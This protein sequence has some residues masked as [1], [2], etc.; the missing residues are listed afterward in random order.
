[1][2]GLDGYATV[3]AAARY[4]LTDDIAL[5]LTVTNLLDRREIVSIS[6]FT[7][8]EFYNDAREV[9]ASLTYTW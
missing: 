3:D 1:M 9:R 7:P 5:G 8:S 6:T 4:Q 2:L